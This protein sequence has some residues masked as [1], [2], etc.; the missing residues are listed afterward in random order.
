MAENTLALPPLMD[1]LRPLLATEEAPVFLVGGA[2]RDALLGR[3]T[4][5]LDFVVSE[6]AIVLAFRVG[7]ALGAPAFVLDRER[8]IARVVLSDDTDLDFARF[9][10]EDLEADL[11][12]RDFTINAMALPVQATTA[13]EIVDPCQGREDLE[14]GVIRLS[15]PEALGDDPVRTMR[16]ARLALKL[17]FHLSP[18]TVEAVQQ[19]ASQL[20]SVSIERVRDELI[21]ALQ[22]P[23]AHEALP[24]LHRLH[25]L[26][27]VLPEIAAL[28]GVQQ[29][30]PHREPVLQHTVSIL[31]W[32]AR[33]ERAVLDGEPEDDPAQIEI[34]ARLGPFA[35]GL[36]QHFE[37]AV[38]GG[39]EGRVLL[40]LGALFHDVGKA[41]TQTVEPDGRIRFLG[42]EKVGAQQAA[43]RLRRLRLSNQAVRHVQEVVRGHMRPLWLAQEERV[44]RRAVYRFFRAL[45]DAGLDVGLISVADHLATHSGAG[46][47]SDWE[48][49][50]KVVE[51][52]YTYYFEAY[53][54]VVSPPPLLDGGELIA[55]L[56]LEPGPQVGELLR[57][58]EEAQAAGE[59]ATPEEAIALA[60]RRRS[61]STQQ[62]PD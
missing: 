61:Q 41:E 29:S 35:E 62:G 37:R 10:G 52:L 54:Q 8:D 45:G 7:D 55:A 49:L 38:D 31:K 30:A 60:K 24:L 34:A 47:E 2:V 21:K 25:L 14:R 57:L 6:A 36:R 22:S 16:A 51:K 11:R 1:R 48:R 23:R 19:T 43:R 13:S 3:V 44:S 26:P 40:R 56:E 39:L 4:Y 32:L 15:Y 27:Q 18:E 33:V 59:I 12:A 46:P 5:D 53:A 28:E 9:R 58:I 17:G 42:H 50:L 20:Q